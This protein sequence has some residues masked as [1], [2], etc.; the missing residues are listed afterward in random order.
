M[1]FF[2]LPTALL[3][4]PKYQPKRV[5]C[6]LLCHSATAYNLKPDT[7]TYISSRGDRPKL[8]DGL[9]E[10]IRL[11][12]NHSDLICLLPSLIDSFHDLIATAR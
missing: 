7:D 6:P 10:M 12:L 5:C 8:H 9:R 1:I 3:E 2:G 4:A 11:R